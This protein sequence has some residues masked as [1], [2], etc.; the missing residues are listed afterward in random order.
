MKTLGMTMVAVAIVSCGGKGSTTSST[1]SSST[2]TGGPGGTGGAGPSAT[3]VVFGGSATPTDP[4]QVWVSDVDGKNQK[5]LTTASTKTFPTGA[6]DNASFSPDGKTLVFASGRDFTGQGMGVPNPT[7]RL[8]YT[9]NAD[10]TGQKALTGNTAADCSEHAPKYSPDGKLVVF[11]RV[12]TSDPISNSTDQLFVVNADGSNQQRLVT[13]ADASGANLDF[14]TFTPDSAAVLYVSDKDNPNRDLYEVNVASH[15][16]SRVTHL[17]SGVVGAPMI[18]PDGK[19]LYLV[20][21][22]PASPTYEVHSLDR[23]G[24]NDKKLFA[25]PAITGSTTQNGGPAYSGLS[26]SPNGKSFV[27]V[28]FFDESPTARYRMSDSN[29]DGSNVHPLTDAYFEASFPFEH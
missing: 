26:L 14:G 20:E 23:T 19:T 2:G 29:L 27:F 21:G 1:S 25:I 10:G 8:I 5:A 16:V 24:A 13:G 15:Q 18:S 22:S 3:N 7:L 6:N 4:P 11:S 12:C 17:T 9:M 28:F